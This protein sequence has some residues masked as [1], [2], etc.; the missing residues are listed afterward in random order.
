MTNSRY[1]LLGTLITVICGTVSQHGHA[2]CAILSA[3]VS[4]LTVSTGTYT[5][6]NAPASQPATIT[7]SG[8]FLATLGGVAGGCQI[9]VAFNRASLPASMALTSGGTAS[10]P[11]ALQ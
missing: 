5:P 11:Y 4:P 10:M 3:S 7:V 1:L 8:T 9:A 6:P 2:V